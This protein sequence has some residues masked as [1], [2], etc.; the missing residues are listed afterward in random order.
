MTGN[1]HVRFGKRGRETRLLRSK[2]V[3][4]APTSFSPLLANIARHGFEIALVAVS[5][6]HRITVIRYA[7]DGVILCEDLDTL[8]QAIA[9]TETWLA[10]M[11]LENKASKTRLTHTLNA[12][13]ENVG[14]D[15]LVVCQQQF[16]LSPKSL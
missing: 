15:F 5:K 1:C 6:R 16:P 8:K 10:E 2:K 14:F 9:R 4:S 11:G 12:Y 7:D 3:R 13:E